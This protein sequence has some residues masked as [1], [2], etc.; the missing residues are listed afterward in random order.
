MMSVKSTRQFL[1]FMQ[2]ITKEKKKPEFL[3]SL[4][5]RDVDDIPPILDVIVE[6]LGNAVANQHKSE[7]A[8][9]CVD[10]ASYAFVLWRVSK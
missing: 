2:R 3:K 6:T 7:V 10:L 4:E 1:S 9:L 8:A 5:R